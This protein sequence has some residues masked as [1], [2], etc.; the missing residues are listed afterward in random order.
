MTTNDTATGGAGGRRWVNYKVL[1]ARGLVNNRV[2]LHRWIKNGDFPEPTQLGPNTLA[3]TLE[4]IEAF[5]RARP[6]GQLPPRAA[7]A[8]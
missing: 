8:A 5:E 7:A 1:K 3:W 2:T 6:K 4:E